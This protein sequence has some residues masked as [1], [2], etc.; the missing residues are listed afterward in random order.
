MFGPL[1]RCQT[2][3]V[4]KINGHQFRKLY[5]KKQI[6]LRCWQFMKQGMCI[7]LLLRN[8]KCTFNIFPETDKNHSSFSFADI[9]STTHSQLQLLQP[10]ILPRSFGCTRRGLCISGPVSFGYLF[11]ARHTL[12][13]NRLEFCV[14]KP[15]SL[16]KICELRLLIINASH[17]Q[18]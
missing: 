15:K 4:Y 16:M 13:F 18:M 5:D 12:V 1:S 14:W 8:R 10:C 7:I 2:K 11:Y 3:L 6:S 9:S 17:V